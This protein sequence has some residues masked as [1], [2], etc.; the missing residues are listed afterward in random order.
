MTLADFFCEMACMTGDE[1]EGDKMEREVM[2]RLPTSG[3]II[4]A[5]VT[6]LG[7][8]HPVL[9][10]RNARR[11][12]AADPERLVKDSTKAEII[13]ALA[14]VLTGAGFVSPAPERESNHQ[15]AP[16]LSSMLQWHT[17][18]WDLMRSG[19]R[20]RTV[21]VEP[22]HLPQVWEAYVRLAVID[23]AL[24]VAAHLHLAGASPEA[25]EVLNWVSVDTRGDFL[26]Q[27]RRQTSLTLE[28]LAEALDV[29]DHTVDAWLY[30]GTRPSNE[31]LTKL[32]ETLA[33]RIEGSDAASVGLELRAL[34][35]VSD[36]AA[37]LAEYIGTAAVA[38]IVGRLRK[39]AEEA[40]RIID[41]QIPTQDRPTDLTVLA[42]LGVGARIATPLL[43]GLIARESDGEWREDL[44]S[45]GL[46]W[47]NRVISVNMRARLAAED[48]HIQETEGHLLEDW[49]VSNP[50][51]Y[52][53]YRRSFELQMQGKPHE[54]LSEVAIA[55]RLDPLDPANHFTL[56]SVKTSIGIARH[57]IDLVNEGMEALWLAVMLDPK[58][59]LPWTEI[60]STLYYTDRPEEAVAH[61]RRVK[62]ECGPPDSYYYSTLGTAE[63]KLDELPRALAAFE[64]ALELDPEETSVLL[65]ASE[66]A[67]LTGDGKKHRRYFRRAQHFGAEE[68]TLRF[69][70]MLREFGEKY[71]GNAGP[72]EYDRKIAVMDA[73]IRLSPDDDYA[74]VTR[75]LAHFA[76]G[77]DD[78]AIADMDAVLQLDPDH[79]AAYMLRGI[80]FGYREQWNRMVADMTE[81]IRLRPA[82][83][84]A[85]Y[86]RG[87]ADGEQDLF[88]QA[89]ADLCEAIRLEPNHADAHRVRGDCLRQQ[90]DYDTA[91]ADF[92]TALRLDTENA[93]AYLGRGAAHRMKGDLSQAIADYDAAVH[94]K[95]D[96]PLAYRFRGDARVANGDYEL[97]IADCNRALQLGAHDP[98]AHFTRGNAHLFGAELEPALA[99]FNAAVELDPSSGRYTY[100][101][102]L[103]RLL[104][105]DEDCAEKD[106]QLARELG[107]DDQDPE[108]ED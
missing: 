58:W 47:M 54:A 37:L 49:D 50:E 55:A 85:Y 28:D 101:R 82:D 32:A 57:D 97:A 93:A 20:R 44:R 23:L 91:I 86:Q 45:I 29:S 34:Y 70:A 94:L 56:G 103:V 41:D 108:C 39:Y 12:F 2:P 17:D 15:S 60:G 46:R 88:D 35:W 33:E 102:G 71:H 72:D 96:E 8:R 74:H 106:F 14:E 26:N 16:A 59:I 6:R 43:S 30:D 1:H 52:A 9:Q 99:D 69:W 81:L 89:A 76:K 10:H 84:Q 38:D 24:R 75:G 31:N 65:A 67:L 5:L 36:V 25:L 79:A 19:T 21:S 80:L 98:I 4:G 51:A 3:Q 107:Y 73:V 11:Y 13:D 83:A 42:D 40:Y 63:W 90:G 87:A 61:L 104:L 92:G 105:G 7:I 66:L 95:P 78:L 22:S 64:T 27:K 100:G 77:N 68:G 48:A 53:H 62:P 18:H